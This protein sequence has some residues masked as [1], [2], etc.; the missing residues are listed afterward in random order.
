[1]SITFNSISKRDGTDILSEY[2]E[3]KKN[4]KINLGLAEE[5]CSMVG[6]NSATTKK[7]IDKPVDFNQ[8]RRYSISFNCM[9]NG[10]KIPISYALG[11]VYSLYDLA[12]TGLEVYHTNLDSY[13]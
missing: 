7:D 12:E 4:E 6:M 10:L 13:T 9:R 3:H 5:L 11:C 1:M 8:F 2:L